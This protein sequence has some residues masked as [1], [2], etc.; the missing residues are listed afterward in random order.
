MFFARYLY[1]S[2]NHGLRNDCQFAARQPLKRSLSSFF[3]SSHVPLNFNARSDTDVTEGCVDR[4]RTCNEADELSVA[5][6]LNLV[7]AATLQITVFS[8]ELRFCLGH[9]LNSAREA[10]HRACVISDWL[11]RN[12]VRQRPG[13]SFLSTVDDDDIFNQRGPTHMS[14]PTAVQCVR[15]QSATEHLGQLP[16]MTGK[17]SNAAKFFFGQLAE[18][19]EGHWD[20]DVFRCT[21]CGHVEMFDLGALH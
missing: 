16:L 3:Y 4:N 14:D 20:V 5:S 12:S 11:S 2:S 8:Y 18:M 13:R 7:G 10:V 21:K 9:W 1:G 19:G 17:A 6:S 15:C